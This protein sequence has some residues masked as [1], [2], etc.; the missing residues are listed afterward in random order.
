MNVMAT[1]SVNYLLFFIVLVL[2]YLL[3]RGRPQPT[4]EGPTAGIDVTPPGSAQKKWDCSTD[5]R[6]IILTNVPPGFTPKKHPMNKAELSKK[7]LVGFE[8]LISIA[9]DIHLYNDQNGSVDEVDLEEPMTLWL[10][11]N[12]E[13]LVALQ[14]GG[15]SID[16]LTP[17]K[18]IP[19]PK[20]NEPEWHKFPEGSVNYE[21]INCGELG[22]VYIEIREWGDPPTGWG[23]R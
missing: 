12:A 17:V 1:S 19:N 5:H 10:S 13:D 7:R 22:G 14:K 21:K 8:K 3:L 11:Y 2:L 16:D 9:V 15:Y 6:Q 20:T 4:Q 18:C 23:T